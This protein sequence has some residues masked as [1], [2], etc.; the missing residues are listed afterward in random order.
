MNNE[1]VYRKAPA[2]P[3]VVIITGIHFHFDDLVMGLI[4]SFSFNIDTVFTV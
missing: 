1:G 2:T 4:M 3:G